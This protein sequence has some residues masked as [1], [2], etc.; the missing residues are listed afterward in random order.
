MLP[1]L[2]GL[3]CSTNSGEDEAG[4]IGRRLSVRLDD[5]V[6]FGGLARHP[7]GLAQAALA[8]GPAAHQRDGA[9]MQQLLADLAQPGREGRQRKLRRREADEIEVGVDDLRDGV[10][11][12]G[13]V[14]GRQ[15]VLPV[16]ARG[17]RRAV[18]GA[19]VVVG[20]QRLCV[21][22]C[23]GHDGSSVRDVP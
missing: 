4:Q 11:E 15:R 21:G 7:P 13:D 19:G 2:E 9:A 8:A 12:F 16:G 17:H 5:E 22:C 1:P 14:S 20:G 10:V 23:K 18:P 3:E 6:I